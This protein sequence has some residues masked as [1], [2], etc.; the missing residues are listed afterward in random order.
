MPKQR[1]NIV[2]IVDLGSSKIVCFIAKIGAHGKIEVLGVGHHVS[3]GIKAGVITDVKMLER[4]VIQAV[5]S[6]EKMAG[7]AIQSAY[8]SI[9]S[10]IVIS[11]LVCSGDLLVTGH[12]ISY[13]DEK[14][15]LFQVL[16][17]YVD[18]GLEVIHS[19]PYDYILDGNRG[20]DSPLGMYGNKL[21]CEYH[22]I[23]MQSSNIVN[24][25]NAFS[26]CQLDIENY[27]LSSYASGVACLTEDE[28]ALGVTLIEFGGGS[29]SVSI[30]HKGHM[31]FSDGIPLGGINITN[32]IARGL[33]TDFSIAERLKSLYGSVIINASDANEKIEVPLSVDDPEFNI[34]TRQFLIEIIKARVE[35]ILEIVKSRLEASPTFVLGGNK[36]VITGGG[37]QLTG[38]RD[39]V[40]KMFGKTVR[41]GYPKAIQGIAESTSGIAF[42]TPIGMLLHAVKLESMNKLG[43]KKAEGFLSGIVEWF[44][45]NFA[46]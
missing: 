26:R 46:A 41:I 38:M 32:D 29:T 43:K 39:I 42:S 6:A 34:V 36:V 11:S 17:K 8:I 14:K 28:I 12:E 23:S 2:G 3:S 18:Q 10:N 15:I 7:E 24:V 16:D 20:I 35:E 21:S 9:S 45:E 25:T 27:I 5:E 33:S 37:A 4:S 40:S 30:F 44:K 31:V 13:K 19:F 1:S 22:M